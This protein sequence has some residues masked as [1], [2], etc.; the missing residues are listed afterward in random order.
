MKKRVRR[1]ARKESKKEVRRNFSN[2]KGS[3]FFAI[4]AFI[5]GGI[6]ILTITLLLSF[7]ASQKPEKQTYSFL[8]DYSV[9]LRTTS[10]SDFSNPLI[11]NYTREGLIFDSELSLSKQIVLF[12]YYNLTKTCP[13]DIKGYCFD[14]AKN[15][16]NATISSLPEDMGVRVSLINETDSVD[17]YVANDDIELSASSKLVKSLIEYVYINSTTMYGPVSL[18]VE[19]WS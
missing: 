4:D 3:Y 5:A 12:N 1:E 18:E 11:T 15:L 8:N 2:K 10:V 7:F 16:T 9:F 19:M 17:L 6:L 14:A 13:V